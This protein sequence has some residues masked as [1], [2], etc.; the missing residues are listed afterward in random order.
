LLKDRDRDVSIE[1]SLGLRPIQQVCERL[2]TE[3]LEVGF[4]RHPSFD[5]GDAIVAGKRT[6]GKTRV[7]NLA[8]CRACHPATYDRTHVPRPGRPGL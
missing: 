6:E 2:R 8:I 1:R 4:V 7:A 3:Q 5:G